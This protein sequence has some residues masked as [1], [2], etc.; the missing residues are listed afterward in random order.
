MNDQ[1]AEA[2]IKTDVAAGTAW[3]DKFQPGWA[4]KIDLN[5]LIMSTW[6]ACVL[7]Q[8]DIVGQVENS[9]LA[10]MGFDLR[11]DL[12][13]HRQD[14]QDE[15]EKEI[16]LRQQRG[17]LPAGNRL[18]MDPQGPSLEERL[19]KLDREYPL[20]PHTNIGRLSSTVRRMKAERELGI[21]IS[22][23]T[24]FAISARTGKPANET[25][26]EEWEVFYKALCAQLK[27]DYPEKYADV[28]SEKK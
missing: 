21:P 7:G 28:F 3:L 9:L 12:N 26:E 4:A 22:H 15:W 14:W 25:T 17:L 1:V 11:F 2:L 16:R 10:D 8:L 20:V 6:S 27:R 5:R 19:A 18:P 24:G 23:R 13:D